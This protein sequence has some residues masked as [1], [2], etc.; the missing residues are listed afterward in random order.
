MA[1]RKQESTTPVQPPE[2]V[3]TSRMR[4]VPYDENYWADYTQSMSKPFTDDGPV[5]KE[6]EV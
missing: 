3:E 5:V 4:S 1:Q 6:G 2:P